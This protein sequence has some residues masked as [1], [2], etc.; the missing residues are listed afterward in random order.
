MDPLPV[1]NQP[2]HL[3]GALLEFLARRIR[4]RSESLLAPLGLRTRHFVAMTVLRERGGSAQQVLAKTLD[5]DGTNVVGLLNDL[6]ADGLIERRRSPEDRRR[7][8]VE[9]TE[10]GI[11]RLARAE[12]AIAAAENEVLAA[13]GPEQREA[14]HGMLQQALNG[15]A[16]RAEESC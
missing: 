12:F 2:V 14:L 1:L 5:M 3:S 16:C 7:H 8:I 13:L 11:E 9:L 4:L 6:E 15:E 10:A